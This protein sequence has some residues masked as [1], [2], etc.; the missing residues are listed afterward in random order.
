[1]SIADD[2]A[3]AAAEPRVCIAGRWFDSLTTDE[4]AEVEQWLAQGGRKS[5]ALRVAR[6]RGYKGSNAMW[7]AHS[8]G[9][10]CCTPEKACA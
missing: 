4:R 7:Y 9:E 2:L 3:A 10:C 5:V 6:G 8:I 1:M